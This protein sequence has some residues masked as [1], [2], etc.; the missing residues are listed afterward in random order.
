MAKPMKSVLNVASEGVA[1]EGVLEGARRATEVGYPKAW[2]FAPRSLIDG[3]FNSIL[4]ALYIN[5]SMIA[6]ASVGSPIYS[7]HLS[8]GSWLAIIVDFFLDYSSQFGG[9]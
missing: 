2:V 6:S 8:M 7:Y 4:C 5:L 3:P 1:L 9:F